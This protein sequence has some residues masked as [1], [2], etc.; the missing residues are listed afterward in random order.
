[1]FNFNSIFKR[2]SKSGENEI[3]DFLD[4]ISNQKKIQLTIYKKNLEKAIDIIASYISKIKFNVYKYDSKAKKMVEDM[5]VLNYALNVRPNLNQNSTAFKYDLINKYLNEGEVLVFELNNKL[6]I[7]DSFSVTNNAINENIYTNIKL[8]LPNRSLLCLNKSFNSNDVLHL[9]LNN[10]KILNFLESYYCDYGNIIETSR[11]QFIMTNSLKFVMKIPG[12]QPALLDAETK[13]PITYEQYKAK[14]LSKLFTE[15]DGAVILSEQINLDPVK[16][17]D[18]KTSEDYLKLLN[19]W[20]NDVAS[21]FDIP[22]EIF[23][24]MKTEKSSA[25]E[26]FINYCIM[27]I[28]VQIEDELNNA[29][30][31]EETYKKGYL[32]FNRYA[33]IYHDPISN[34]TSVDKLFSNGFTHNK[35][36]KFLDLETVP[37]PWADE[38]NITKNY[39]SAKGGDSIEK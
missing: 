10:K 33:L 30:Y 34:A 35:I 14:I 28:L 8:K 24:K 27:P 7:A 19:K 4:Y 5:G 20:E 13:M 37:E 18:K 32:R 17:G 36:C 39:G 12:N 3:I 26:D 23:N 9:K 11:K 2:N 22:P 15:E 21:A 1:M 6:Y 29:I 38:P 16:M 31:K 25:D